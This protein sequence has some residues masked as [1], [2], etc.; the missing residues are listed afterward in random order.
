[1]QDPEV[2]SQGHQM[3]CPRLSIPAPS[4]W[5]NRARGTGKGLLGRTWNHL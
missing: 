4:A 5:A 2:N 1:M 3:H